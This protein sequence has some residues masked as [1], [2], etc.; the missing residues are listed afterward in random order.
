MEEELNVDK[1]SD[2]YSMI[3]KLVYY[4]DNGTTKV[5]KL[6]GFKKFRQIDHYRLK[7]LESN[8]ITLIPCNKIKINLI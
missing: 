3:N 8:N 5:K 6:L 7:D 1:D 2:M 4:D